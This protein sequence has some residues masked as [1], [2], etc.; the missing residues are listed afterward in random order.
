MTDET[1]ENEGEIFETEQDAGKGDEGIVK[2]WLTE[3]ELASKEEEDWR[4]DADAVSNLY[5]SQGK[6][7]SDYNILWSNTETLRA[8]LYDSVP[9]PDVRR[10][11][12]DEDP[13]GKSVSEVMERAL[14][15]TNDSFDFDSV[16]VGSVLDALL[17]GRAIAR[18]AYMP[19]FKKDDDGQE[20]LETEELK[21]M[22][23]PWMDF[24]RGPGKKWDDVPWLCFIH[25]PTRD[26]LVEQFGE[27]GKLVP[28]NEKVGDDDGDDDGPK[29]K[30]IFKRATAYEFW[31]KEKREVVWI[32]KGYKDKPL[33]IDEDPLQLKGFF[34]APR[35]LYSMESTDSLIPVP[36]YKQYESLAKEL[37]NI[38]KRIRKLISGLR[39]RG[40]YDA[41]IQNLENVLQNGDNQLEPS[42]DVSKIIEMGGLDKAIWMVPVDMV[43]QVLLGLYQQRESVRASIFEITGI[44]DILR[45][46]SDSKE[47]ATAQEIKSQFGG[48]R[49]KRRQKEVQRFARDIIRLQAEIIAEKFSPE[50]LRLMTGKEVTEEMMVILRRDALR[51][52]RIDIETDSTIASQ[53][54]KD[55]KNMTE[56][57]G[58]IASYVETMGPAVQQGFVPVEVAITLLTSAIRRFKLGREVEDAINGIKT[59]MENDGEQG[60]QEQKPDPEL[61]KMQGEQQLQQQESQARLQIEQQE[62]QA[63]LQLEQVKA[64]SDAQIQQ[65]K[66]HAEIA[67]LEKK[68]NMEMQIKREVELAKVEMQREANAMNAQVNGGGDG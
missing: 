34:P 4:K 10:R 37:D 26:E 38:T 43:A 44:S 48:L 6:G 65:Q 39:L 35:P 31:D 40:I 24:R 32:G 56:L 66:L 47:T 63:R 20:S 68:L 57:L 21:T 19:S 49:L 62:S 7:A 67:M 15:Y 55:E 28:L 61:I 52:F 45:G 14:A 16:M 29:E 22:L 42:E 1:A 36:E 2:R 12:R 3:F 54:Q 41:T 53:Q 59:K 51:E 60:Q 27:V 23:W 9:I 17:P 46:V 64:Q 25:H 50:T 58:G 30:N 5:R 11:F 8:A 33:A 13:V 18:V